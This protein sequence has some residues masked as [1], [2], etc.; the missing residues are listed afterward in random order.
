MGEQEMK[1]AA[2]WMKKVRLIE[3]AQWLDKSEWGEGLWQEE[4]DRA[5]W[6]IGS[7]VG[8]ALRHQ[9]YGFWCGY[10]GVPPGHAWHGSEL[11]DDI[12]PAVHGGVTFA[13]QCMEDE[14][15]QRERVCHVPQPGESDAV[16]WLGFDCHHMMDLAPGWAVA[17]KKA[18]PDWQEAPFETNKQYRDL[19]YVFAELLGMAMVASEA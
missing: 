1:L 13:A 17:M 11:G 18:I 14:R 7:F 10:L 9:E 6:R 12:D 16:W 8:L 15:P 3:T 19:K 2:E 5:E 4:P